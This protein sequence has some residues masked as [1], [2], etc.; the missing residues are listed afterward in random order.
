MSELKR[1]PFCGGKAVLNVLEYKY[2][3][4]YAVV[5]ENNNCRLST[6]N[7]VYKL[8]DEQSA[9]KAWNSRVPMAT[10]DDS[11][12]TSKADDRVEEFFRYYAEKYG[13]G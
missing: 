1:C 13:E 3:K 9:I 6:I 12:I 11:G 8:Q 7:T 2:A 10:L 5:C 4:R